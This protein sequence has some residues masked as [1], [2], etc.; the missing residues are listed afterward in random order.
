MRAMNPTW[1]AA[2]LAIALT[3]A[4][5]L[6]G[7]SPLASGA[8]GRTVAGSGWLA[9][10]LALAGGG[11]LI[12]L[13]VR[14]RKLARRAA[15]AE[16]RLRR[17]VRA[18]RDL[19]DAAAMLPTTPGGGIR[20]QFVRDCARALDAAEAAAAEAAACRDLLRRGLGLGAAS[21]VQA[22]ERWAAALEHEM[23]ELESRLAGAREDLAETTRCLDDVAGALDALC[24]SADRPGHGRVWCDDLQ[25]RI[26][27]ARKALEGARTDL[28]AGKTLE[29]LRAGRRLRGRLSDLRRVL[30]ARRTSLIWLEGVPGDAGRLAD[31]AARMTS[32]GHRGLPSVPVE[33]LTA[34]AREAVCALQAGDPRRTATIQASLRGRLDGLRRA[35]IGREELRR[36]NMRRIEA[37][38]SGLTLLAAAIAAL[39]SAA[40]KRRF[41]R[42]TWESAAG[43]EDRLVARERAVEMAIRHASQANHFDA[44]AFEEAAAAITQAEHTLALA[45]EEVARCA[46]SWRVPAEEE[47]RL[48]ARLAKL[49]GEVGAA[50]AR[51]RA[52]GLAPGPGIEGLLVAARAGLRPEPV[53]LAAVERPLAEAERVLARFHAH[54]DAAEREAAPHTRWRPGT[55]T[56][57][58]ADSE[59]ARGADFAPDARSD[60]K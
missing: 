46:A 38:R 50:Y 36:A 4:A 44:Q 53:D 5:L 19:R 14:A 30:E 40:V 9:L 1:R 20:P 43:L 60:R 25:L 15:R 48:H 54:L 29:A 31:E 8:A 28:A 52:L 24:V 56:I 26:T 22:L 58:P 55:V 7:D 6:A 2:G 33:A 42:P 3:V 57:L 39:P 49:H 23:T 10:A 37:A 16:G 45:H 51:A 59:L 27:D 35:I 13:T 47:A 41:V 12:G 34:E 11:A 18:A 21:R 32:L 17:S